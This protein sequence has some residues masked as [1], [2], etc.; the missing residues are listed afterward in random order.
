MEL[1]I[2][3]GLPLPYVE[4]RVQRNATASPAPLYRLLLLLMAVLAFSTPAFFHFA[5]FSAGY[6]FVT[7]LT[8]GTFWR[9]PETELR[10]RHLSE[11]PRTENEMIR[12][13]PFFIYFCF[14]I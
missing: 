9:V 1:P 6:H 10:T 2:I 4:L 5:S 12:W 3:R 11:L 14:L 7:P 13:A 8:C